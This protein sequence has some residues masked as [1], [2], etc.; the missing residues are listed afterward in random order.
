MRDGRAGLFGEEESGFKAV[1]GETAVSDFVGTCPVAVGRPGFG[2]PA[3]VAAGKGD[4]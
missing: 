4:L 1:C 3:E 2:L